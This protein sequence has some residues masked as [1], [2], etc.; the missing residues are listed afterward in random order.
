MIAAA[1]AEHKVVSKLLNEGTLT[2][3][4]LASMRRESEV[5]GLPLVDVLVTHDLISEADVAQIYAE[6]N[7][8]R[9]LDLSRR[10]PT[11][12]WARALERCKTTTKVVPPKRR[13]SPY[14]GATHAPTSAHRAV[15]TARPAAV[16]SG[17]W[18]C[19]SPHRAARGG[20]P[21]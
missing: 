1:A 21:G 20:C 9:F 2:P 8:L 14:A 18:T 15:E 12:A 13:R 19:A 17:A 4:G 10:T 6:M 11:P 5:M 3:V 16:R 7:G